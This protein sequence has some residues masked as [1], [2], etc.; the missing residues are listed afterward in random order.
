[1]SKYPMERNQVRLYCSSLVSFVK[2]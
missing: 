1:M 2:V